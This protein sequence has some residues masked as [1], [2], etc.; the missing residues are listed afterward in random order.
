M[1]AP[2]YLVEGR[3]DPRSLNSAAHGA[4]RAMSRT[5]AKQSERWDRLREF[6]RDHGVSLLSAGLD[7]SPIAYKDIDRVMA[8]QSDLVSTLGR[9]V[10][11]I[12]KMAPDGERA[13]D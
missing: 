13:E 12:V 9:F 3:G 4:G 5:K 10:P 1:A 6:L 2:G 8:A 7:E 11:R